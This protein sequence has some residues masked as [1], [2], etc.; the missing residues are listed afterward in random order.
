VQDEI[1]IEV[2]E[3]SEAR[4]A[5]VRCTLI[6]STDP[7]TPLLLTDLPVVLGLR[8]GTYVLEHVHAVLD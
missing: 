7:R 6:G 1:C 8:G 3:S 2:T 5:G 4:L